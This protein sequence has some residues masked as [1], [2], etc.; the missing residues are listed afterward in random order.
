MLLD[1]YNGYLI[2]NPSDQTL[3]EYGELEVKKGE[4]EEKLT[5]LRETAST[6]QATA[7]TSC[8]RRTSSCRRT[9]RPVRKSGAEGIGL[10]R[11]E[12]CYLNRTEFPDEEEQ[13]ENYMRVAK[14][15]LPDSVIIRTLDLGGD[16]FSG[17][18]DGA[19]ES[20]P[21]LG[22]RAIRFCL[23]KVDVFKIQLRAI[24]RASAMGNVRLMYPMISGR[25][26]AAPG[27]R[28]PGGMPGGTADAEGIPFDEKM[29]VGAMIEVP[30]AAV[31][32]DLIAR[33][34][35][36][37][38]P[39][40]ERPHPVHHR[41]RPRERAHRAPL[42]ADAPAII[43]LI[44]MTVDAAH[45]QNRWVGLCGEIAG[46]VILTPLLIGLGVDEL[47]TGASLVP[48][49]E[50]RRAK[51]RHGRLPA[52][53]PRKFSCATARTPSSPNAKRWRKNHYPDLLA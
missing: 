4:V 3:W 34:A 25:R 2:L 21:F 49:S 18:M 17:V 10:Y 30:S 48:A 32:A 24:L 1:G 52:S 41:H 6:T 46:E 28:H 20:N 42:R 40:D 43:R 53:S 51:P 11:T 8:S 26:R 45:A 12:F 33:E 27:K 31:T 19:A 15:I 35:D 5:Q 9:S 14:A 13:F 16:K 36:F 50:A 44:K 23:E 29:E 47:S 7:S 38:Q 22:W 39:R 37:L